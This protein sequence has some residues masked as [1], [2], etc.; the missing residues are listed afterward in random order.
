M[1]DGAWVRLAAGLMLLCGGAMTAPAQTSVPTVAE[2]D[3]L[4]RSVGLL[5]DISE[6]NRLQH[7]YGYY[8]DR[9]DWENIVALLTDDATAEYGN[10]GVYVGKA[11]IRKL[12]YGIGYDQAGLPKGLLREHM[13]FQPVVHVA[14]DGMTAKARWR[15]F[16]VLGQYG[17][18]ARWQAG[19]YENEFRKENGQWKISKI[20]WYETFTVPFEGG[21]KT[22]LTRANL[23]DRTIPQSDRPPTA[24]D[25]PWPATSLPPYHYA[26]SDIGKPCCDVS[27]AATKSSTATD[28]QA[29]N[30]RLTTIAHN[31]QRLEDE[32]D[33]EILQRTYGYYVDKNLWQQAANLFAHNGTLEI[34][35]RGVFVG[36]QRVLEYLQ[37][38]GQ[39]VHGRLYD[40]TQ[41]QP[42]IHV[43]ADGRTAKGR[44]RALVFGGE[45]ERSNVFGDVIYEN[46]YVKEGDTWKISKL[47][48]WFIMYTFLERGGWHKYTFPNTRPE[49]TLPPDR[50]PTQ[51]YDAYPGEL[52]APFHFDNPVTA[53]PQRATTS[54]RSR[55]FSSQ[56]VVEL[57]RRA[58][59]LADLQAIE[60]LQNAYG[61]YIDKW[62]WDE[63]AS[64]FA[65][66]ATYEA[67]QQ[68]VYVGRKRIRDM[69]NLAGPAG[70]RHGEVND[71]IQYQPVTHISADGRTAKSRVRQMDVIGKYGAAA[72]IGG[73]VQENEYVKIDGVWKIAKLHLYTTFLADLEKG[74]SHGAQPIAGPSRTLPPDRGPTEVYQA[75]PTF[76]VPEFHY[77]HPVT[78][79]QQVRQ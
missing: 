3:A 16:A 70:L 71:R 20:R 74:W 23:G 18:Y 61:Y 37:W 44:W 64:L 41:A 76:H 21:W 11:S 40:H 66:D 63:A 50:P 56:E 79:E 73:G 72:Y 15:V 33:I 12:L 35:G 60:N 68:G 46:E 9:S 77:P 67:G 13:Q 43:S 5:Q 24:N 4:E 75:F 31:L 45:V 62:Q 53:P 6:V 26:L 29:L 42:V 55:A 17:E 65:D 48:A 7:I 22:E 14:P 38:L 51:V 39:P 47:H 49:K 34:G 27:A 2:V 1:I 57:R 19:P 8:L 78:G 59:A 36:K 52:A 30:A 28:A 32:R 10:S 25:K 54:P 58:A 69:F